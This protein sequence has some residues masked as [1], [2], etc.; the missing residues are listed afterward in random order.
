MQEIKGNSTP[1]KRKEQRKTVSAQVVNQEKHLPINFIHCWVTS[2]QL[3]QG[4]QWLVEKQLRLQDEQE[5]PIV[6]NHF[7][8]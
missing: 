1:S 2:G 4:I 8:E 3:L 5:K 6:W 7:A